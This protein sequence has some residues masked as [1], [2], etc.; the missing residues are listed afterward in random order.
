MI[1]K[2]FF[3]L[4]KSLI[5]EILIPLGQ[6]K[7]EFS[8]KYL[9]ENI[10]E[11][12]GDIDKES[13]KMWIAKGLFKT[14]NF[15]ELHGTVS[16]NNNNTMINGKVVIS[17]DITLMFVIG[18]IVLPLMLTYLIYSGYFKFEMI[19]VFILFLFG[20]IAI[21][22]IQLYMDKREYINELKGLNDKMIINNA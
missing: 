6:F 9:S 22:N 1:I 18:L 17:P 12:E 7:K 11:F 19:G 8:E 20:I 2:H 15:S 13:F 10:T 3:R 4:E 21:M 5:L 16:K 14:K